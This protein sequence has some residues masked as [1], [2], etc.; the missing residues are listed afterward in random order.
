MQ[1]TQIARDITSYV[2][3][4]ELNNT[5]KTQNDIKNETQYRQF[6]QTKGLSIL[7]IKVTKCPICE[8]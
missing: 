5:I 7:G 8:K 3:S 2:S 6:L 1:Y 4:V